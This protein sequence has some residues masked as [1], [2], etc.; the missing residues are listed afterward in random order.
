[1]ADKKITDLQQVSS[2][3]EDLNFPVDDTIQTYRATVAQ[4]KSYLAPVYIPPVQRNYTS[5]S[6][7]HD[8]GF[9]FICSGASCTVGATYTNNGN[10]Y[11][12]IRTVS[13]SN[14]A[15]MSGSAAPNSSGTLAKSGGTGD[16]TITFSAVRK[17][18]NLEV[19]VVGGGGGGSGSGTSSSGSGGNGGDS[20]FGTSLLTSTGGSGGTAQGAGGNGGSATVSSPAVGIGIGGANGGGVGYNSSSGVQVPGA[21]GGGTWLAS[22]AGGGAGGLGGGTAR[23]NSGA[24]G[25][26]AGSP[27]NSGAYSGSGGGAG[28]SI[29]AIVHTDSTYTWAYSVGTNGGGGSA[30]SSGQAGGAGAAGIVS[31]IEYFQ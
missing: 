31:V 5:G 4:I 6:G 30:G 29:R 25:G 26:G 7:S 10:T 11:T 20:S 1:M 8:V 12:V 16:S 23:A 18:I 28:G 3:T 15:Y 22:G 17:A 21:M 14:I 9:A 27:S 2:I 24:G 19:I 13:S